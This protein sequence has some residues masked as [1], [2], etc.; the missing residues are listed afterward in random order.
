M[1]KLGVIVHDIL[2]DAWTQRSTALKSGQ[3]GAGAGNDRTRPG[4]L[5]RNLG[6]TTTDASVDGHREPPGADM[7]REGAKRVA[8]MNRV[9]PASV[10]GDDGAARADTSRG[11]G[12]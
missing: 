1:E 7:T 5:I 3:K 10:S 9:G 12:K 8:F 4:K 6:E 11:V 2:T